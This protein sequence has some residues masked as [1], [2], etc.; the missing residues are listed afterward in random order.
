MSYRKLSNDVVNY[1]AVGVG[2][3]EI[4]ALIAVGELAM[5]DAEKM[6]D[7]RIAVGMCMVPGTHFSSLLG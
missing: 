6:K 3:A 2:E 5:I 4:A 1:M 7:G